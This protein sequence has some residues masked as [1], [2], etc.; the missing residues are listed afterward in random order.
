MKG[1]PLAS[2]PRG[3]YGSHAWIS[4]H[5]AQGASANVDQ[6]LTRIAQ[7]QEAP[8]GALYMSLIYNK[9]LVA[10]AGFEP[11]AFRL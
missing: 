3:N 5:S 8:R 9:I 2:P 11:A 6:V 1:G 10:G 7:M 4:V